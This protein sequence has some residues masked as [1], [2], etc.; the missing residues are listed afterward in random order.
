VEPVFTLIEK[1]NHL[2]PI[3]FVPGNHEWASGK[4]NELETELSNLGVT[5][6]R[7]ELLTITRGKEKIQLLG[8]DDLGGIRNR[9]LKLKMI[10]RKLNKVVTPL[11]KDSFKILLIHRPHFLKNYAHSGVNLVFAGHAHGGQIR[12]PFIGG[13][14]APEQ[15]LFPRFT[16]GLYRQ[17]ETKLI[18]NRGLGNSLI[19]QRLFN[20]PEIG[21]IILNN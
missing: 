20:R 8:L 14:V 3:Y 4:V 18:V 17:Q 16:A 2:A 5:V 12:L 10:E 7:D 11:S 1:I 19:P 13:L 9:N 6:L 21:L 15:G